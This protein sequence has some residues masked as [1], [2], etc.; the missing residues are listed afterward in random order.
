MAATVTA[1]GRGLSVKYV[2][3]AARRVPVVLL[4]RVDRSGRGEMIFCGFVAPPNLRVSLLLLLAVATAA[5]EGHC[6]QTG[7]RDFETAGVA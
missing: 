3:K 6:A 1:A 2:P 7:F 5:R 4:A